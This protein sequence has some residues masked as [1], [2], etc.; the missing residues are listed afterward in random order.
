ML[1]LLLVLPAAIFKHVTQNAVLQLHSILTA[2]LLLLH[3]EWPRFSQRTDSVHPLAWHGTEQ[4]L[5]RA[6]ISVVII[7]MQL[8]L[9][10]Q[11]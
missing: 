1:V 4:Q 5:Q 2:V 10:A 7:I 9:A 8:Q 6:S 11:P 3:N